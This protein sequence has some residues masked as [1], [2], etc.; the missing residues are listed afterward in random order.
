MVN[1]I[2]S[3]KRSV[4][5]LLLFCVIVFFCFS[6]FAG[7]T[8]DAG[9]GLRHY[10]VSRY[11]W[12]HHDLLLYSWGKPFFTIISSPFSQFGLLG[13]NLFNILCAVGSAFFAY[14][15]AQQLKLNYA[16][17]A[18]PFLLFTPCYFPTLNSGLTEPLFGFILIFSIY[19]IFVDRYLWACIIFSFLPFV[20]TE[21]YFILPLFFIVLVY[22]KKFLLTPFLVFGSLVYSV[23]GYFY[24]NDFFWIKNQNP[25]NGANRAFYGSG[26]LLHFVKNNNFIW[27]TTLTL[28]FIC[29]L[30]A[31][32]IRG[33][34][35][36]KN[37]EIKESKL[38]E[39]LFLIYGSFTVYFIAHSIM[40][41]KGLAN[42]LGLLRVIA[43]VIPCS[44]LIC[45]R[46]FNLIMIPLF[47]RKIFL[48]YG[49]IVM[50]LFLVIRSP[51]KHDYFPYKLD[52][53]QTLINE[54]GNW[55]K[56][57]PYTKQKIY[58]IYPLFAHVL[59]VDPFNANKIGELWGLYPSIKE[60]G[61]GVIP[62]STIVFWDAHFGPNECRIPLDTIMNDP[63]FKLIKAFKP[64]QEFT[65]LGGYKFE[66]YAFMKLP[67]PK[68]LKELSKINYDLEENKN[69]ENTLSLVGK[70]AFSG[71]RSCLLNPETE[72]SA[73]FKEQ[74][75]N[76]PQNCSA[77]KFTA[78]I[79]N[80]SNKDLA[81]L[82]V[83]SINDKDGKNIH[84][85]SKAIDAGVI[86]DSTHWKIFSQ[87][88]ALS[89]DLIKN[90]N[91]ISIYVW[92]KS[93]ENFLLD[94]FEITYWGRE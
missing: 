44:A 81:A 10:L 38:P 43:G 22:K 62:D 51:F 2:L 88:F 73:T 18:I 80:E 55:Y 74:T 84:W 15:I 7:A 87:Q 40:W 66:V 69:L 1:K 41:W 76:L 14:K 78:K 25:Y 8:Y 23:I 93:K 54:A 77:I 3:E 20:R 29:G 83:L 65:C 35:K 13:I 53:E 72:Y 85:E 30:I 39:E 27:G 28:L 86:N 47:K 5:L 63:N 59:N 58:Y 90:N 71:N 56:T 64:V 37:K 16:V 79:L 49:I 82:V 46:G 11:C 89:D 60:W 42:S 45:L 36:I 67:K 48:E 33:I 6:Y 19:L 57:S 70:K 75:K 17:L 68:Q 24:F 32:I 9:D 94:D 34:N 91:T 12:E 61:I 50:V 21:G 92:N 52:P 4:L 31:I 26:E